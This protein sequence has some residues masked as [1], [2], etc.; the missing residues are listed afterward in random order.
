M[1]HV[2]PPQRD[3]ALPLQLLQLPHLGIAPLAFR[4]TVNA[5]VAE[6][7]VM[8]RDASQQPLLGSGH[9]VAG[10]LACRGHSG[11]LSVTARLSGDGP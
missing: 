3:P 6:A 10:K 9:G 7:G 11:L 8:L 1:A 2:V 5:A 4:C